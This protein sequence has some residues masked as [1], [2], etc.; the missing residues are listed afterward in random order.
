MSGQA[1]MPI[2]INFND[3][4]TQDAAGTTYFVVGGRAYWEA[5]VTG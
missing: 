3:L 4:L 2:T 1:T 5:T